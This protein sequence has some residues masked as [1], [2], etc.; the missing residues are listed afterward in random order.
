M[1]DT[2][3]EKQPIGVERQRVADLPPLSESPRKQEANL[4]VESWVT[5]IEKR[6]ARIPQ[7]V[8]GPQDDQVVVQQPQS[9]QPPVTLPVTQAAMTKGQKAPV[10]SG[11]AWLVVWAI[12]RIK[13]LARVGRKVLLREIPEVNEQ[14]NEQTN[15]RSNKQTNEVMR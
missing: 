12:R 6:F 9:S 14:T 5:K 7:G 8:P 4:E 3:T 13:M 2:K 11:I 10:E 15:Q 1:T